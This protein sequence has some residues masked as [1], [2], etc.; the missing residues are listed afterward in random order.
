[1]SDYP[2][3]QN[4]QTFVFIKPD[5]VQRSLVGTFIQKFEQAGLKV[6]ASK[7]MIP[8]EAKLWTHYNKSDD[9]Y[10]AKGENMVKNL[11]EKGIEVTKPAIEYGKDI[12]RSLIDFMTS[13]PVMA[14]VLEGNEA[15]DTVV[16][17]VGSTEPK[18]SDVGTI[19]G[20]Y[21]SDTYKIANLDNRAVRNLM[22]CSDTPENALTEISIWFE[23]SEIVKYNNVNDI[24]LYDV[25]WSH[26]GE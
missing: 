8:E 22:H 6:V 14:M 3:I 20:D 5:A 19:R 1:M 10:T 17:L 23:P 26:I 2:R 21:T 11:Q 9:W 4:Q 25:S 16:K 7:F 15:V 12:V 13:G 24:I 18:S